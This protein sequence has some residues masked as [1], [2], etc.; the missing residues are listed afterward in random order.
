L[1]FTSSYSAS[2]QANNEFDIYLKYRAFKNAKDFCQL[3][4]QEFIIQSVLLGDLI[5]PGFQ[6]VVFNPS[7]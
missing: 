1:R 3:I 2:R 6:T 5:I 4:Y 7:E